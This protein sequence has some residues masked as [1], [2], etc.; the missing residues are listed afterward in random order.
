MLK[1]EV[2]AERTGKTK[3]QIETDIRRPKYFSASEAVE[4]GLIDKVA[5]I[6][7]P[8]VFV[9][10]FQVL[11]VYLHPIVLISAGT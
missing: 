11:S 8:S 4:Y 9:S 7:R 2:F 1:V 10:S 3:E 5:P 6:K